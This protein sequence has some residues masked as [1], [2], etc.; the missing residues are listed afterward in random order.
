M[1]P[2]LDPRLSNRHA[3][4]AWAVAA[5]GLA[6]VIVLFTVTVVGGAV[7]PGYD[8]LRE[9]MSEL[10]AT[11]SPTQGFVSAGFIVSGL[12]LA[13]FWLG[14]A[15]LLPRST[16]LIVGAVFQLANAI[17]LSLAGVYPCD[18]QC[19]RDDPSIAA[20]LHDLFAGLGYLSALIGMALLSFASRRWPLGR[21]ILPVGLV[22]TVAGIFG[23]GGIVAEVELAG[24]G[25]RILETAMAIFTLLTA[26][27]LVRYRRAGA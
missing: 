2:S 18:F 3:R 17:G 27:A 20:Q 15:A 11:G 6:S 5:C 25:Q 13:P 4:A 24:L 23:F 26:A 22:C 21:V 10:G 12:L 9:F 1:T 14:A 7:Y 16:L 8:H 19:V